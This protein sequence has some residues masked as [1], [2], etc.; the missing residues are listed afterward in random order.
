[1]LEFR[2]CFFYNLMEV[3]WPV[4]ALSTGV[5]G[6]KIGKSGTLMANPLLP[7][8]VPPMACIW[9]CLA[10][11]SPPTNTTPTS[12]PPSATAT[13]TTKVIPMIELWDMLVGAAGLPQHNMMQQQQQAAIA[14]NTTITTP[15][16]T[17][18]VASHRQH[19]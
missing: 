19:H 6:F 18:T 9:N 5:P 11:S 4:T 17:F 1:M 3:S 16:T 2:N 7:Q 10:S 12:P 15:S 14:T 13:T 8:L